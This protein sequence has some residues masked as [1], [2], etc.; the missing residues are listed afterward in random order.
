MKQK[1]WQYTILILLF[2]FLSYVVSSY[3]L[4][5][6]LFTVQ[7]MILI[8]YSIYFIL[9]SFIVSVKG[10]EF[11]FAEIER[12]WVYIFVPV[13]AYLLNLINANVYFSFIICFVISNTYKANFE[14]RLWVIIVRAGALL[15]FL[16]GVTTNWSILSQILL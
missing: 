11:L 3:A 13:F 10:K 16:T 5:V 8:F 2:S 1:K 6:N 15:I 12:F 14:K 4:K 9:F 7:K